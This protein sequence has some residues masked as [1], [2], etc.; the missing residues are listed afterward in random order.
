M[1]LLE[2]A[3]DVTIVGKVSVQLRQ[4]LA[5][6]RQVYPV[7]VLWR[8]GRDFSRHHGTVYAAAVSYHV[9]LS[10]FPLLIVLVA[11]SGLIA[12]NPAIGAQAVDAIVA[13]LP[14]GT[15]LRGQAQEVTALSKTSSGLLG[16]IGLVSAAWTASGMFGAL[17]RA[18][19]NAF[20]VPVARS[21]VHGRALDLASMFAVLA[22]GLLSTLLT[23][24]LGIFRALGDR[25]VT[26]FLAN[27]AWG[28]VYALLPLAISVRVFLL[29][30]RLIPN[31]TLALRDLWVGALVA[32]LG[33]ELAKAAFG[34]H[35]ANFGR[36]QEVYGALGGV[37]A[38]LVF[39]YLVSNIVIFGAELAS[40]LAKDRAASASS[41]R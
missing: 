25:V 20:D 14:T 35:L 18:L 9:L 16:L 10:L 11:V 33:F 29:V 34:L 19:N 41:R 15:R 12:R 13:Q 8:G 27:L 24:A 5:R 1:L 17:R 3:D 36:Y 21:F 32:A 39:V 2:D 7:D 26:G 23:T 28:L 37:V 31:H 6:T 38:F 4:R 22:L 30:Y 40:E